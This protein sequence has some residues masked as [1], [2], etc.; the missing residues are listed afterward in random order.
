MIDEFNIEPTNENLNLI[1]E[2]LHDSI[3]SV[4][5]TDKYG[6]IIYVNKQFEKN[7]GYTFK[8]VKGQN[9]RILKSG[10]TEKSKYAKLWE[11][12]ISGKEWRGEFQNKRKN[13]ELFYEYS[14]IYPIKNSSNEI[15]HFLA[16][17]E[18]ITEIKKIETELTLNKKINSDLARLKFEFL[19]LISHELRTPINV[20]LNFASLLHEKISNNDIAD[21]ET[22]YAIINSQS[23][24]V[25][26]T[27][28]F[29]S[30]IV[31]I[32]NENAIEKVDL[33]NKEFLIQLTNEIK[34]PISAILGLIELIKVKMNDD[35]S[36]DIVTGFKVIESAGRRVIETIDIIIE[37]ANKNLSELTFVKNVT[38]R[39][40][41]EKGELF[42]NHLVKGTKNFEVDELIKKLDAKSEE[43]FGTES[44]IQAEGDISV[45]AGSKNYV[46]RRNMKKNF[47]EHYVGDITVVFVNVEK[48]NVSIA[49]NFKKYLL[50]LVQQKSRKFIIDLSYCSMIDSTFIGVLVSLLKNIH[51][52]GG[53]AALVLDP[54]KFHGSFIILN[55]DLL[56]NVYSAIQK[57]VESFNN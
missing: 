8:E 45:T 25:L 42:E 34:A 47:D 49:I 16:I 14:T 57:A 55:L 6:S 5:L 23:E 1:V 37:S 11:T 48:A 13:G 29:L 46:L 24:K 3:A 43:E 4:I 19:A 27:V 7:T 36:E 56:F 18:D 9:P 26:R 20:I 12:I 28:E 10:N 50:K 33:K 53:E 40:A 17:K 38:D 22:Y 52:N 31:E 51:N 39:I 15:T 30:N 21:I 32:K 2:K 54:T 44:N 41:R 35:K